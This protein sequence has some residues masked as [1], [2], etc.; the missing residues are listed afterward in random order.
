MHSMEKFTKIHLQNYSLANL[1]LL[2]DK[3]KLFEIDWI[4]V[5][6]RKKKYIAEWD[7]YYNIT[8]WQVHQQYG[9]WNF[10]NSG[11]I[12][13]LKLVNVWDR[14][15]ETLNEKQNYINCNLILDIRWIYF[16][17]VLVFR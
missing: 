8:N 12:R 4:L 10:L 6:R 9:E 3:I 2:P 11:R 13:L 7:Y 14:E 1:S 16:C 5:W 15:T 17:T